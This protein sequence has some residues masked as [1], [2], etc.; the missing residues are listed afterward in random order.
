MASRSVIEQAKGV[1]MSGRRCTADEALDVLVKAARGAD[2]PLRDVAAALV[3][4]TQND[5]RP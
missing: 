5:R 4:R 3:E 1:I 2:Q